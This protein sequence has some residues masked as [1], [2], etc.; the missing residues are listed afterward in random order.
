MMRLRR[1]ISVVLCM[2]MLIT[3]VPI[4]V[5]AET[6]GTMAVERPS[7]LD[8]K[9]T[10]LT[11]SGG[12]IQIEYDKDGNTGLVREDLDFR[13]KG[14]NG[15]NYESAQAGRVEFPSLPAGYYDLTLWFE[16]SDSRPAQYQDTSVEI[17]VDQETDSIWVDDDLTVLPTRLAARTDQ[18]LDSTMTVVFDLQDS[19]I[20]YSW[21]VSGSYDH[22]Y[23][24]KYEPY[25]GHNADYAPVSGRL[26]FDTF[27][28]DSEYTASRWYDYTYTK[29][30]QF[31]IEGEVQDL[32]EWL[33]VSLEKTAY[34]GYVITESDSDYLG[35]GKVKVVD[36]STDDVVQTSQVYT[37]GSFKL[38]SLPQGDYELVVGTYV[39]GTWYESS[40]AFT[41]ETTQKIVDIGGIDIMSPAVNEDMVI[42]ITY[43][44]Y[45]GT[46]KPVEEDILVEITGDRYDS[47]TGEMSYIEEWFVAEEG[48]IDL[49][50]YSVGEYMLEIN[51]AYIFDRYGLESEYEYL[52][53]NPYLDERADVEIVFDGVLDYDDYD[54]ELV[55]SPLMFKVINEI[56][57]TANLDLTFSSAGSAQYGNHIIKMTPVHYDAGTSVEE[58]VIL[59]VYTTNDPVLDSAPFNLRFEEQGAKTFVNGQEVAPGTLYEI[60]LPEAAYEGLIKVDESLDYQNDDIQVVLSQGD[61]ILYTTYERNGG[62]FYL[63]D[64]EPGTYDIMARDLAQNLMPTQSQ[65]IIISE[66]GILETGAITLDF[67]EVNVSDIGHVF[68]M[69]NGNKVPASSSYSILEYDPEWDEYDNEV[70][71][72]DTDYEDGSFT[73]PNLDDGDYLLEFHSLEEDRKYFFEDVEFTVENGDINQ[74]LEIELQAFIFYGKAHYSEDI[75]VEIETNDDADYEVTTCGDAFIIT[76]MYSQTYPVEG[77]MRIHDVGEY[78]LRAPSDWMEFEYDGDTFYIDNVA[79]PLGLRYDIRLYQADIVGYL[80]DATGHDVEGGEIQFYSVNTAGEE[81][82]Y[83]WTYS[84]VYGEFAMTLEPGEYIVRAEY[85]DDNGVEFISTEARILIDANYMPVDNETYTDYPEIKL[86]LA[87]GEAHTVYG[88]NANGEKQALGNRVEVSIYDRA[89][90]EDIYYTNTD[91]KGVFTVPELPDGSYELWIWPEMPENIAYQAIVEDIVIVDGVTSFDFDNIVCERTLYG[92]SAKPAR[93]EM[94]EIEVELHPNPGISTSTTDEYLRIEELDEEV[95]EGQIRVYSESPDMASVASAWRS[96]SYKNGVFTVDGKVMDYEHVEAWNL[97]LAQFMGTVEIAGSNQ[98]VEGKVHIVRD[99]KSIG[100]ENIRNNPNPENALLNNVFYFGELEAGHYTL[101]AEAENAEELGIELYSEPVQIEISVAGELV[102][103]NPKLIFKEATSEKDTQSPTIQTSLKTELVDDALYSFTY[104]ISDNQAL[105][106]FK[107]SFNGTALQVPAENERIDLV[108]SPG[109]NTIEIYAVDKAGNESR[110]QATLTYNKPVSEQPTIQFTHTEPTRGPVS[111]WIVEKNM[112]IIEVKIG[113]GD[114]AHLSSGEVKSNEIIQARMKELE[115]DPWSPISTAQVTWIDQ[116]K[117]VIEA[118]LED[119]LVNTSTLTFNI[120]VK[121]NVAVKEIEFDCDSDDYTLNT[122]GTMTVMLEEG[123]NTLQMVVFDTAGN[124]VTWTKEVTLD[125]KA[126]GVEIHYST[127]QATNKAVLVTYE[128]DEAYELVSGGTYHIFDTNGKHEFVLK[129]LAGNVTK[130]TAQVDWIDKMPIQL[131]STELKLGDAVLNHAVHAGD[132]ITLIARFDKLVRAE[133]YISGLVDPSEMTQRDDGTYAWSWTVP[134]ALNEKLTLEL[135]VEDPAG[136]AASFEAGRIWVDNKAPVVSASLAPDT[137]LIEGYI[138]DE[139]AVLQVRS[140]A[141]TV[142]YGFS[143]DALK[144]SVEDGKIILDGTGKDAVNQTLYIQAVDEAGNKSEVKAVELKWD[145]VAPAKPDIQLD[146][147]QVNTDMTTLSG[148]AKADRVLIYKMVKDKRV[149]VANTTADEFALGVSVFLREGENTFYV[150]CKDNADNDSEPTE[151]TVYSDRTKPLLKVEGTAESS[152]VILTSSEALSQVEM[153]INDGAWK[154]LD[155]IA[156]KQAVEIELGKLDSGDNQITIR[157]RDAFGNEGYG[158]LS[159]LVIAQGEKIVAKAIND[160]MTLA[161]GSFTEATTLSVAT[162]TVDAE[163]GKHFASEPI[164]FTLEGSAQ[165]ED[166][167]IVNMEIGQGYSPSTKLYYFDE[168]NDSWIVL[169]GSGEHGDSFYNGSGEDV[170]YTFTAP[171]GAKEDVIIPS[172]ELGAMLLHFS[173]YGAQDDETA[174]EV[175]VSHS[176]ENNLSA[177]ADID[178]QVDV[179]EASDIAVTVNGAL[180]KTVS[181]SKGQTTIRVTLEEGENTLK[182]TATDEAGNVSTESPVFELELDSKAPEVNVTTNSSALTRE[183]TAVFNISATDVRSNFEKVIINQ[184]GRVTEMTSAS[185]DIELTLEEGENLFEFTAYDKAGN[186]SEKAVHKIVKDTTAPEIIIGGASEGDVLASNTNLSVNVKNNDL[187]TWKAVLY[188]DGIKEDTF[189]FNDGKTLATSTQSGSALYELRVTAEDAAGNFATAKLTFTVDREVPELTIEG[190][191]STS[192]SNEPV[193]PVVRVLPADGTD[194]SITLQKD[195][196]ALTFASGDTLSEDGIYV[197]QTTAVRNGKFASLTKSFTIDQ[198]KPVITVSG[199]SAVNHSAVSVNFSAGDTHLESVQASIQYN[200]GGQT[201]ITSGQSFSAYGTYT[202][203]VQAVDLAGNEAVYSTT[204]TIEEPS[205]GRDKDKNRDDDRGKHRS[206]GGGSSSTIVVKEEPVAQGAFEGTLS[207][208]NGLLKMKAARAVDALKN[209]IK[210]ERFAPNSGVVPLAVKTASD[211]ISLSSDSDLA[212][213]MREVEMKVDAA[214]ITNPETLIAYQF[215]PETNE[216]VAAGGFYNPET[217]TLTFKSDTLGY[218][219]AMNVEKS[220]TDTS[221]AVWAQNAIE[222]LASRSVISGY[223]DGSY[224]PNADITRAEFAAIL[225]QA[226]EAFETDE[227]LEFADVNGEWYEDVLK[228]AVTNGFMSGYNGEMHPNDPINREQMA[229]MIMN[230]FGKLTDQ[231]VLDVSMSY[232]DTSAMSSWAIPAIAKADALGIL[233]DV[234]TEKYAPKQNST[235]AEA[236]VMVYKMLKALKW[237]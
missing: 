53:E 186:A 202:V 111:F 129:D 4:Q 100:W 101:Q 156:A 109:E 95:A 27:D 215:N 78:D 167:L 134:D 104:D 94:K 183:D 102:G 206:S 216:W 30:G 131:T 207:F 176:I 188:K 226:V 218:F 43:E 40:V 155:N 200:G 160:D 29:E 55:K 209:N 121:D 26:Q 15:T 115:S 132:K 103:E 16:A 76:K 135:R 175:E 229:V 187:K 87:S 106:H 50:D 122:D 69:E 171:S 18:N 79:Y 150:I 54:F 169:D 51:D 126:P 96:Y 59:E 146:S 81:E 124:Y 152:K 136:N 157:G 222:T 7:Q 180:Q 68:Y 73:I 120:D 140:S 86:R 133:A 128:V 125:T 105:D 164:D 1:L 228:L 11:T 177:E 158:R 233:E 201:A 64:L 154:A 166:Y 49:T 151:V 174:P 88:V 17:Y 163:E 22:A 25:M 196:Q 3:S 37:D 42:Q 116:E 57:D 113:D 112:P 148:T 9:Y 97:P 178:M 231:G 203:N 10:Y 19:P 137:K 195:G 153:K 58:E 110:V 223:G 147:S 119:S 33:N 67:E 204:F 28:S 20:S 48:I 221:E 145:T 90:E 165:I 46:V 93:G 227:T 161:V 39:N 172:G 235:R 199:F 84:G 107:L 185:F 118:D 208:E 237:M 210:F 139:S 212:P 80:S 83:D 220:F 214:A 66:N 127:D 108:L 197:L 219:T 170:T 182:V 85:S 45:D 65:T 142:H 162:V 21:N 225:C 232:T 38:P 114:W 77:L 205:S 117:P 184:N 56:Q 173:T 41:A 32:S 70:Y 35:Y 189:T 230:A 44:D 63:P 60:E 89:K 8:D 194:L 72:G 13:I 92:L 190:L 6:E 99:S 191:K 82:L 71:N 24:E 91:E 36:P 144:E 181:V 23:V 193:R 5:F 141:N 198:M 61:T 143:S 98:E 179:N 234:A 138:T 62:V 123:Q 211:I 2:M 75:E 12:S 168:S 52:L 224:K 47:L 14:E 159:K 34:R 213:M 130:F 74:N 31:I 217:G 236:A 149:N 192:Y